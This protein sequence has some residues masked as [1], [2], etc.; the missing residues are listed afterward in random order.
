MKKLFWFTCAIMM[1]AATTL[2]AA[3]HERPML[4][5]V[6]LSIKGA[7][8]FLRTGDF[9]VPSVS[10]DGIA[11][12][13]AD[14]TDLARL[15]AAGLNPKVIHADLVAFYQSRNPLGATMGGYK[16]YA[17][18]LA[19]MDSLHA[20]YPNITTARDSIGPTIQGRALWMMKI[21]D[22]PD[23]NENEPGMFVN[24]LIHAREP[25]GGE[26]CLRFINYLCQN[27]GS[28]SIVT[29][30]VNN[31]EFYILP[32]VN[33]DG[34]E[35][36]RQTNP[37]GGGMWRKNRRGG[38][39]IDLNRNWGYE[40]GY[41]NNGSSP[42]QSD[43]T[44]RGAS[45]FS[46][47]ETESMRQ[48]INS[49]PNIKVIMN[50]H[51]Y[52]GYFLYPWGYANI[53]APDQP[54]FTIIGDSC[55]AFSG[56]A[57]GT[58]WELLYNT[59]GES[60][61]WQYGE[62]TEK[63]K[64]LGFV[65]EMGDNTDGFWAPQSRIP[66]LWGHA[67]SALMYLAKI[68]ENP[69]GIDAPV[70]P[71]LN[72]IGDIYA[73][74]FTVSWT[75]SDTLNPA[76]AYELTELTGFQRLTDDFDDN[77]NDWNLHGFVRRTTHHHSG[78]YGLYGGT[79]FN[80]NGYCVLKNPITVGA[81]DT[82]QFWAWYRIEDGYDYAYVQLSTDG[83]VTFTNLAGNITTNT[84]PHGL[85]QG[86]GITGL[87]NAWVLAKFPLASYAGQSVLL[88]MRYITDAGTVLDGFYVDDFYPVENFTNST[89]LSSNITDMQYQITGRVPGDYYYQARAMDAQ[90]QWS[91][92]SNRQVARVQIT[93]ID[94]R[95]VLPLTLQLN[96]NYPNPFNP[97]TTISF[98]LPAK[99]NVELSVYNILGSKVTTLVNTEMEAGPHQVVFDGKDQM[100]KS[101]GTG[102]YFYR[103]K[104]DENTIT[105]KMVL[106][107]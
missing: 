3:T 15:S 90:Q 43:E 33:P 63:P 68:A 42:Y 59:N 26:N 73:D 4:V 69:Y 99:M 74:S 103:L 96:Q 32:I 56:Y 52:G 29:H 21:S 91:G 17:E 64:M 2:I 97:Q 85:N 40:W 46:E 104:T 1:I 100:G 38:Y 25:M 107:K 77:T 37:G 67:L 11:D 98:N 101:V 13:I 78:T 9:D 30:L 105:K 92:S 86:N 35:Y 39:G 44:Y 58:P 41:D 31:R 7:A 75:H 65:M 45:A 55:T 28:D 5:Q 72:P 93:G 24:G 6:D 10:K 94:D 81:N 87:S 16:T 79:G 51:T 34:Y 106:M 36:N 48:F 8:E 61:D 60:T 66:I 53:H 47:S 62:Q 95:G 54:L 80:Y 27:Y 57:Q 83:G 89:I 12:I 50:F 49:H 23:S 18:A 76:V 82:L 14:D 84:N 102:V 88:G 19:Y 22:N 70:A 71:H 20:A